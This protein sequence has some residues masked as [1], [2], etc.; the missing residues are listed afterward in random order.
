MV[1]LRV[2]EAAPHMKGETAAPSY[3]PAV[4]QNGIKVWSKHLACPGP[5]AC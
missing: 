2:E 1:T 5:P 4:L 3:K